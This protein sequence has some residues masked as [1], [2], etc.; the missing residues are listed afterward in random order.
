VPWA[1]IC[2]C[3]VSII[4]ELDNP[5]PTVVMQWWSCGGLRLRLDLKLVRVRFRLGLG[6]PRIIDLDYVICSGDV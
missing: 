3:D 6:N 2:S 5:I 1:S 4:R